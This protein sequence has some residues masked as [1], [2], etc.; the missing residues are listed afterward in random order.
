MKILL[1]FLTN[2]GPMLLLGTTLLLALATLLVSL[3]KQPIHRQRIAESTRLLCLLWLLLACIPL[4]RFSLKHEAPPTKSAPR[5]ILQSGDELI[6]AEV[7]KYPNPDFTNPPLPLE[8]LNTSA[9]QI[10]PLPPIP[11]PSN[12]NWQRFLSA[13]YLCGLL[14]CALYSLLGQLLLRRLFLRSGPADPTLLNNL[15][16]HSR[17]RVR[18]SRDCDRPLSFGLFRPTILLPQRNLH[19]PTQLRHILLHELAHISQRDALGHFLFN[20]LFP[21][22][23]FHPLYWW[24][25]R[26]TNL[27]RELIADDFAAAFSSRETY[28]ADLLALAKDRLQRSA[29]SSHALG[30]FQSKS[31]LYRRMQM[32]VQT[33]RPLDRQCS[34]YWRL[35]CSTLLIVALIL[36]TGALGIRR[37]NAQA[38]ETAAKEFDK[39]NADEKAAAIHR[40]DELAKLRAEQDQL[41]AQ[42]K[43]LEAQK[44]QIQ[45]LLQKARDNDA[46][47]A[48]ITG[49]QQTI[50]EKLRVRREIEM[51]ADQLAAEKARAAAKQ[52]AALDDREALK[53]WVTKKNPRPADRDAMDFGG[54]AQL[55]LVSLANSYVDAVGNLQI[56]EVRLHANQEKGDIAETRIAKVNLETARRKVA[57]F[58]SIAEAAQD[59]AKSD[60]EIAVQQVQ[61]GLAPKTAVTEAESRLKILKVILTQ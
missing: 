47:A 42:L 52:K 43:M 30:L 49:K 23:Y 53:D 4:P 7:F 28:V 21:I 19:N 3:H 54:R 27:A 17:I 55:D 15:N 46:R 16:T 35:S 1:D 36:T 20:L 12:I 13:L 33:N 45:L 32:L 8:R 6:A 48:D 10:E 9:N 31:D 58:R 38:D 25:R 22:L 59:A 37:A 41:M 2:H 5:Y 61:I 40:D 39:R 34:L 57:I 44:E 51:G 29:L 18:I 60:L 11:A 24:L 56:A 26:R 50:E 14:A